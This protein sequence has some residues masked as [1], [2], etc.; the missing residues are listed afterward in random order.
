MAFRIEVKLIWNLVTSQEVFCS[1]FLVTSM[2]LSSL[3]FNNKH[4]FLGSVFARSK[5]FSNH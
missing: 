2:A 4:L 5:I 1:A 3:A